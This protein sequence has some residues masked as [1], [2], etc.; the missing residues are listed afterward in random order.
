MQKAATENNNANSGDAYS[1]ST[2]APT[3]A[4][5]QAATIATQAFEKGNYGECVSQMNKLMKAR[6]TDCK[7]VHNMAVATFYIGQQVGVEELKNGLSTA[8]QMVST[9]LEGVILLKNSNLC[10][11]NKSSSWVVFL[12]SCYLGMKIS[13]SDY[14][15]FFC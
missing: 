6:K 15:F 11:L 10:A 9:S 13:L 1:G 5:K 7:V 12:H 4:D 14:I 8:C 3:E 2:S